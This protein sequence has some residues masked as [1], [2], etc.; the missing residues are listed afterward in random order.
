MNK[1]TVFMRVF[2]INKCK[3]VR[4]GEKETNNKFNV[5]FGF[6]IKY[7]RCIFIFQVRKEEFSVLKDGYNI[8]ENKKNK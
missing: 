6:L 3:N 8:L 1:Q 7:M 5:I 4:G 2:K